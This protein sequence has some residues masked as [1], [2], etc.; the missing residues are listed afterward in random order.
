MTTYAFDQ[1]LQVRNRALFE[2]MWGGALRLGAVLGLKTDN[3]LWTEPRILVSYS[4]ND[5]RQGWRT[6]QRNFRTAKT[7]E[8]MIALGADTLLWLNR[9]FLE[10]RPAEAVRL[11]HGVF[12]CDHH[13]GTR[14]HGTPLR[15][16]TVRYL[17]QSLS[18]SVSAG[19]VGIHVT[20]HMLRHYGDC[21]DMGSV[22]TE[23]RR[24]AIV[25][26]N[27]PHNISSESYLQRSCNQRI[28]S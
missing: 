19:G 26:S 11:N 16:A 3:I 1:S 13:P 18:K 14:N 27:T 12:F 28:R 5:Y 9:Y 20:P 21:W 25:P 22:L 17:F 6:K 4:E 8:Y 10:T 24:D 15:V 23:R 7:G 2:V